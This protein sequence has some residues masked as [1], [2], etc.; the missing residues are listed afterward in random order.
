MADLLLLEDEAVIRKA[1]DRLLS[2][3]GYSVHQA[4]SLEQAQE[5]W[6]LDAFDLI[7]ADMRLPG[8]PGTEAIGRTAAPVI[9]MTSYASVQSAVEAMRQGAADYIAKP[10]DHDELLLLVERTLK[11]GR[12]QRQNAALKAHI[13]RDYPVTGIVGNCEAMQK[14]FERIRKVAPTDTSVLILGES[15]TGK[16]LVARALHEQSERH[17]GPLVA[18][19]CAAIPDGLIEAELFG[20]ERGAFTGAVGAR[21]GLV[22]SADGGT[23]FLD[24]IGE[25]PQQAQ[26]RLLRVLQE[27]EIRRIG[28]TH[29]RRVNIRLVAATH[30]DLKSL[31]SAGEFR[32][33]LFFRINV[34]EIRLPPVREREADI[35][36]LAR[37]LL[38]KACQRL[39]RAPL[40]LSRAAI[41]AMTAYP[42]PG[43]V[44]EMENT[45]ER[46]VILSEGS[47][48]S[49]DM[50]G[51]PA[52]ESAPSGT[53]SGP[54]A[55]AD[56]GPR[57][58][59]SLEDY[60]R[61]YVLTHQDHMT[62][63]ALARGL[64]I[65]RKAL[66]EKRQ[67]HGIPRPGNNRT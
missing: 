5:R 25:L 59:L 6:N 61:Q 1:L 34:M 62:E 18:V 29:A 57:Q 13:E 32:E 19:N 66:W 49:P 2:R 65:S 46:A 24:E 37:F 11:E 54:T 67:R 28:S 20:H 22:E 63:T 31:A 45:I 3:H 44:R 30:R 7:L 15:G 60:F 51:L 10:F 41:D 53:T 23:L 16:E 33:D 64:G 8:E 48:I 58:D 39:N 12:L 14:V 40:E 36:E 21:A 26:G 55:E 38:E 50:L 4:D 42:W 56:A 43:N 9:I 17:E 27:G 47:T 35:P 52:G